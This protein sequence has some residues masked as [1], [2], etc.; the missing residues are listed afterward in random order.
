[1]TVIKGLS[2][3]QTSLSQI[4]SQANSTGNSGVSSLVATGQTGVTSAHDAINRIGDA[5]LSGST[6]STNELV[7]GAEVL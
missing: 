7:A 3:T 4:D 2:D 5:L 1:M 6:P